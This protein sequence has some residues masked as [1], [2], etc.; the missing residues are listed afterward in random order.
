[1]YWDVEDAFLI[2]LLSYGTMMERSKGFCEK[3]KGDNGW[4]V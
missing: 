4:G 3:A 2:L 1:M